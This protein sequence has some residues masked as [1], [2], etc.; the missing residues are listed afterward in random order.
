[1]KLRVITAASAGTLSL[2]LAV[3]SFA[4]PPVAGFNASQEAVRMGI[5]RNTML[6]HS[7]AASQKTTAAAQKP[8][9]TTVATSQKATT[10]TH[11]TGQ[12]SQTCGSATAPNTPG[13]ASTAPG[14]AFNPNGKA[15]MVYAGTQPQNSKNPTSVAQYD[16]ACFHQPK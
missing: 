1:L 5:L 8:A 6:A 2:G 4:G 13:N 11:T 10:A 12:P 15:G 9:A 16:V 3:A 14:S 7:A